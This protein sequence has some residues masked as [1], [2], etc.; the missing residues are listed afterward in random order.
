M[1]RCILNL[2]VALS[3]LLLAAVGGLWVRSFGHID[4]LSGGVGAGEWSVAAARGRLYCFHSPD[5]D[6]RFRPGFDSLPVGFQRAPRGQ[7]SRVGE[8]QDRDV[9]SSTRENVRPWRLGFAAVRGEGTPCVAETVDASVT[10]PRHVT[11]PLKLGGPR[12]KW[13]YRRHRGVFV[14]L[15]VVAAVSAAGPAVFSLAALRSRKRSRQGMCLVCGYDLRATPDRCP[16]CGTE[17]GARR[18]TEDVFAKPCDAL[19]SRANSHVFRRR[20]HGLKTRATDGAVRGTGFNPCERFGPADT[21]ALF[22]VLSRHGARR[23]TC[24]PM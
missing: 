15:W 1:K 10:P 18:R 9:L 17:T 21:A 12:S 20:S 4:R 11:V 23:V 22:N 5:P 6:R 16:E 13:R 8:R 7:V 19:P 2:A 24:H 3:L 14:P